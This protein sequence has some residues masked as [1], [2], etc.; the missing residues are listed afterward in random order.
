MAFTQHI[1]I[2]ILLSLG[3]EA[4]PQTRIHGTVCSE[5]GDTLAGANVY[6][7]NTFDGCSSDASGHFSFTTEER[8]EQVLIAGMIGYENKETAIDL[9][10]KSYAVTIFLKEK[11]TV[12]N[13]AVV[14]AGSAVLFSSSKKLF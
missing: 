13:T 10:E 9:K 7:K 14:T 8:N 1:I 3:F 11:M 12:L 6:I 4:M 2:L 5:N